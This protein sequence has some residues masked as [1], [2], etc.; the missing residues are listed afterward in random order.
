MFFLNL[1]FVQFAAI[2]ASVSAIVVTLYLLDRARRRQTVATLRFWVAA[3]HPA[4]EARIGR[5]E[6]QDGHV[7]AAF[8]Q[9]DQVGRFQHRAVGVIDLLT[10]ACAEHYG[11]TVLHYD[12]DFDHVAAITGQ[13]VRWVVPAGTVP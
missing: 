13:P 12:R 8:E 2:L 6:T 4:V 5:L 3:E 7:G 1:T 11:A 10:A 9:R